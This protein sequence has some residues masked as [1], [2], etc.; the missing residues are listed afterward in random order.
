VHLKLSAVTPI[1]AAAV[2]V[3]SVALA[4]QEVLHFAIGDPERSDREVELSLDAITDTANGEQITPAQMAE[5]LSDTGLLFIGET[6][7]NLDF[8]NVQLRVI[9]ELHRAGREVMLG[10]EM[11]PFTQQQSLDRWVKD[12]YKSE[13]DFLEQAEW[14][15][16]WGYNWEYYREIFVFAQENGIPMY[17]VNT[18]RDTVKAVRRKG[19]KDLSPEE[20]EHFVH[21]VKPV[22]AEQQKMFKAFFDPADA[23]HMSED[24]LDGMLRAQTVWDATMGWNA[25]KALQENGG[26]EAIMVVLIGS[27]HVTYG[28]GSERQTQPYYDGKISSVIPLEIRDDDDEEI[29]TVRA[30]YANFVW[31]LPKQYNEA[32]PRMGASLMGALG[33]QPTKII[34]VSEDSVADRAGLKVGDV[35]LELNNQPIDSSTTMRRV[36]SS[37]RWGDVVDA[38]IE[39]D[40]EK[41]SIV[42][43]VR[44]VE[45]D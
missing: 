41:L 29:A 28:L 15:K 4:N 34:Q 45:V 1:I 23:L 39:R 3:S 12:E 16:Y 8:H 35:L 27:G 13:Q 21:E 2:L 17:G 9:Q 40:G 26:D 44:R 33:S 37:W 25:L 24:A 11:F 19:F 5:Q 20:A 31:G 30:S 43:P 32:Y 38:I 42:I 36:A 22:T 7:T 10:L 14:H 6:H 18:P